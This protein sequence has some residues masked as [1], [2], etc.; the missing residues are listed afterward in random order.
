MQTTTINLESRSIN[1]ERERIEVEIKERK[2]NEIMSSKLLS[3]ELWHTQHKLRF[4]WITPTADKRA[5]NN[6]DQ[7]QTSLIACVNK[8]M[9]KINGLQPADTPKIIW[10]KNAHT[11]R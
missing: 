1:E 5:E 8:E 3:C 4:V 2:N 10:P 11:A 6:Y 9:V 7:K